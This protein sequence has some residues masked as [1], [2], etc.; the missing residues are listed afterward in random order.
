MLKQKTSS[1]KA[2]LVL[3]ACLMLTLI[4][5]YIFSVHDSWVI[6]D[7]K[8]APLALSPSHAV[9]LSMKLLYLTKEEAAKFNRHN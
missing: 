9:D 1:L 7:L 5:Y 8:M 3:A 4:G 6:K 2:K